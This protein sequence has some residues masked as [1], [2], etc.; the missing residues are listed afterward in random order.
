[1][2]RRSRRH[3]RARIATTDRA[4]ARRK[5]RDRRRRSD[6]Q[7]PPFM[8]EHP[9]R[10]LIPLIAIVATLSSGPGSSPPDRTTCRRAQG[11]QGRQRTIQLRRSRPSRPATSRA[12]RA[13]RPRTA[14]WA[15]TT[16]T[17]RQSAIRGSTRSSQRFLLYVPD[18]NGTLKLARV[19]YMVVDADQNLATDGDRPSAFGPSVQRPDAGSLPD[20]AHPLRPACLA[21]RRQPERPVRQLEPG[22]Q[23]PVGLP[24]P[25]SVLRA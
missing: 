3:D 13:S 23:L 15:S 22:S 5:R 17:G 2:E 9:M 16:S 20:H 25:R 7:L 24:D 4:S 1:M 11:G 14:R 8:E 18:A 6:G 21:L 12:A 10:R 19:E